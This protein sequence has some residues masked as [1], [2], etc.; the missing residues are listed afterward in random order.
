MP[1]LNL[2]QFLIT[3]C[4]RCV[5]ISAS[6]I[7]LAGCST[8]FLPTYDQ[9][10]YSELDSAN[11][12]LAKIDA[13]TDSVLSSPPSYDKLEPYYTSALASLSRASAIA[14]AKYSRVRK[15][16]SA[17]AAQ[18]V[19]KSVDVCRQAVV[20]MMAYN[21]V[22]AISRATFKESL[23]Q[24]NCDIPMSMASRLPKGEK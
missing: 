21:K 17:N 6:G 10:L 16:P 11:K 1:K 19:S 2:G 24:K 22:N 4:L 8:T 14:D 12:E 5:L 3:E 13:A 20:T 23:V 15:R 9:A 7:T 18:I